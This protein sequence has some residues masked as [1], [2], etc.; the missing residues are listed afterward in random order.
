MAPRCPWPGGFAGDRVLHAERHVGGGGPGDY[1]V[2]P[3]FSDHVLNTHSCVIHVSNSAGLLHSNMSV[4]IHAH[5]VS[6]WLGGWPGVDDD[7]S[8]LLDEV[9]VVK[10]V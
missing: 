9:P 5:N 3:Q 4:I 7:G 2:L 8:D 1:S 10:T 6:G